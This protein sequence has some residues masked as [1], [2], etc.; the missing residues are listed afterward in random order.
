M[1][2]AYVVGVFG[3]DAV[4]ALEEDVAAD[5]ESDELV[6]AVEAAFWVLAVFLSPEEARESVR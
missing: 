6:D 2:L 4:V 5:D 3:D 1:P